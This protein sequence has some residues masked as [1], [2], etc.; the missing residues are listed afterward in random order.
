M[1]PFDALEKLI[2]EHGSA[3]VLREHLNLIKAQNAEKDVALKQKD[4]LIENQA[5][6][7][8]EKD[9]LIQKLQIEKPADVCPFCRRACGE[10][11][12]IKPHL[13]LGAAGVKVHY[14]KCANCGKE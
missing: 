14:Y 12:S 1:N 9:V 4:A 5:R 6:L 8:K 2:S 10:L 7:L 13:Y 11:I 3:A